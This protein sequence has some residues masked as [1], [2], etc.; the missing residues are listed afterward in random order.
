MRPLKLSAS[1]I[2]SVA[3]GASVA[4]ECKVSLPEVGD[5]PESVRKAP[6]GFKWVGTEKLAAQVPADG[7]WTGM[8]SEHDYGDKWWWWREGYRAR[9]EIK[10]E[11]SITATRLDDQAP[12]VFI[13]HATNAYGDNWD[14]ML[15]GM[16]FPTA[17]CWE[18]VAAYRGHQL[19]FVFKVGD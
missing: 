19:R 16:A 6:A 4:S 9:E 3:F 17:G 1:I 12:S 13:S 2:M 15:I 5:L 14:R 10:P 11:L 7:H 8:G 18:V